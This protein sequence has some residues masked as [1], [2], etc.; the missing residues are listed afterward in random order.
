ML[1]LRDSSLNTLKYFHMCSNYTFDIMHNILEGVAQYE[2]KLLF[3]YL[4]ENFISGNYL[5]LRIYLFDFG[6]ID[7]RN[8][9]T[10][11]NL[12]HGGNSIGLNSIL[13]LCLVKNTPLLFGDIA[14]PGNPSRNLLL[15]F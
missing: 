5:L 13:I 1:E 6:Y 10:N 2:L 9:P 3:K 4:T 15:F 12:E 8:R 14:P 7:R 11:V